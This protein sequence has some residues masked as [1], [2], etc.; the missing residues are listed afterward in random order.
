MFID[1]PKRFTVAWK[2]NV[3]SSFLHWLHSHSND[4][5]TEHL[6]NILNI[7]EMNIVLCNSSAQQ[8]CKDT[9]LSRDPQRETRSDLLVK[10]A[11]APTTEGIPPRNICFFVLVRK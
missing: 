8:I 2:C 9:Y 3:K 5:H 6:H 10:A 11:T 1:Y 7:P 4:F